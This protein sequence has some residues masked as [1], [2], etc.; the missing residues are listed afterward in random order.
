MRDRSTIGNGSTRSARRRTGSARSRR[1]PGQ[2]EEQVELSGARTALDPEDQEGGHDDPVKASGPLGPREE[3]RHPRLIG[4][5]EATREPP[6]E[7][8]TGE[9]ARPRRRA[10][11]PTDEAVA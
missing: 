6:A 9:P 7:R 1:Q 3:S 10:A 8:A 2:D 4:M 11:A 5:H